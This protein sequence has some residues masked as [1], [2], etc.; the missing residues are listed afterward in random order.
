MRGGERWRTETEPRRECHQGCFVMLQ[1]AIRRRQRVTSR[2]SIFCNMFDKPCFGE[3]E[4]GLGADLRRPYRFLP[5]KALSEKCLKNRGG[6]SCVS[7]VF[8]SGFPGAPEESHVGSKKS[9]QK[10]QK[11]SILRSPEGSRK[12]TKKKWPKGATT[13]VVSSY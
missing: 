6:G 1:G 12:G 10:Y 9:P 13:G 5:R 3:K 8:R 7:R 4:L 2:F 11:G